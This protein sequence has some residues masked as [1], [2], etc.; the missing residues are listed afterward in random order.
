MEDR[1]LIT[2]LELMAHVGVPP[3]ERGRAQRLTVSLRLF[4]VRGLAGLADDLANTVDYAAVCTAVRHVAESKQRR[5]I[6]TLAE[7]IAALLI[8]RFPLSAVEIELR[9]YIL[10][11]TEYVA[12]HIRRE[13]L[14]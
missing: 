1:I 10:P 12:V 7:D 13:R 14:A 6:E 4:P 2:Q 11:A 5:L 3:A 9:K 8:A